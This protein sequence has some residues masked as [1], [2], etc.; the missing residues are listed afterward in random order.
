MGQGSSETL[1]R[2]GRGLRHRANNPSVFPCDRRD[3]ESSPCLVSWGRLPRGWWI[4]PCYFICLHDEIREGT[5]VAA[6]QT[7]T[8]P[9]FN[10]ARKRRQG[11]VRHQSQ[12]DNRNEKEKSKAPAL[13]TRMEFKFCLTFISPGRKITTGRHSNFSLCCI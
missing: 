3:S 6:V 1:S 8:L 7:S 9:G 13:I 10:P 4:Q 12:S 2:R 11:L 5:R